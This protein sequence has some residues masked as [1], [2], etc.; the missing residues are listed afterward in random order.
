MLKTVKGFYG[1]GNTPC[2]IFVYIDERT[3]ARWY[4]V[5][6]SHNVNCTF[7]SVDNG[8]GIELLTDIETATSDKPINSLDEL[9]DYVMSNCG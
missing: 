3:G 7:D 5:D 6:G 8:V 2:K 1:T 4:C 9:F